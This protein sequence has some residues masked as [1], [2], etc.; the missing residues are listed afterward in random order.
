MFQMMALVSKYVYLF[1]LVLFAGIGYFVYWRKPSAGVCK[2]MYSYQAGV[3][4]LFNLLSC[5]LIVLK[6]WHETIPWETFRMLLLYA[7]VMFGMYI[8][9]LTL[10]R[11][12]NRL[13]WN[14][15]Y[16]LL[17]VGF[18]VLWRLDP[19][20]A[21]TQIYWIAG[22]F[23]VVNVVLLFFRGRWIWKIPGIVFMVVSVGLIVLPFIFP[24]EANG[25]LNWANIKGFVFQPSEFVKLTFAFFIAVLY[26]K[27]NKLT[28]LLQAAA[29]AGFMMLVLLVQNDLG[30]LLIFGILTWMMTY[31]YLDRAIVLWGGCIGIAAGALLAYKFVGHVTVRFD[32][33]MDPW[34]DINGGG[35]Q[36]AQS[37]FAITSGGWFG[38]GLYQG[39]PGYIPARTTD[40]IFS[41]ISEEFGA[42]FA[43]VL[44][45]I[46]LLM[47]LFVMETGRREKNTFRRNLLVA[48]GILFMSQTF[49]IVGGV[50]KLIPLTGVTMPFISYGGSS[51]LS[52]FITIGIIEAVIRLYRMDREEARQ[53]EQRRE[54]EE[55]EAYYAAV[56]AQSREA[57]WHAQRQSKD[58]WS[59]K[60]GQTAA[61]RRGTADGRNT[62]NGQKIGSRTTA[63]GKKKSAKKNIN[64]FEFDD[65]F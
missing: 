3:I 37:L 24:S 12:T 44:L 34:S 14:C 6:E 40:M 61:G 64:P 9:L 38:T 10:H 32:I 29:V 51:L 11:H 59:Q 63:S 28:S 15:V 16:M 27:T 22:G 46:Y 17:S 2:E 39:S 36:I 42:V 53:R 35:Y 8:L 56:E 30:A 58:E 25:S 48:F 57:E 4:V 60:S 52:N 45:L 62:A 41:A 21:K 43:I 7:G 49:I 55:W 65:P 18:I 1:L 23:A 33:W 26:T 47:F 20:T 50:I 13:L 5:I 31:D 54:E 19:D